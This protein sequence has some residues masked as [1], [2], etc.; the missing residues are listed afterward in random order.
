MARLP[1]GGVPVIVR[2]A[3]R[4]GSW[5]VLIAAVA[6]M[7]GMVAVILGPRLAGWKSE[8]VLSGSMEPALKVGGVAFVEP[9]PPADVEVG[10]IITYRSPADPGK[11]VSHRVIEVVNGEE[12]LS[13]R[14]KGDRNEEPD[15]Q[16]VKAESVIGE[17]RFDLPY[18]GYAMDWLRHRDG[19][20]L[21]LMAVP[22]LLI[23]AGEVRNIA[24][25]LARR[26]RP[27]G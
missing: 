13:F 26:R 9:V 5:A 20:L 3:M 4:L 14:T 27:T 2:I 7:S 17:V 12:G 22:A 21:L 11:Q 16:L 8:I 15:G 19:L 10:D 23:I 18:V 1:K 6:V 25:E 24:R